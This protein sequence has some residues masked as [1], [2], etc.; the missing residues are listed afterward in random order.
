MLKTIAHAEFGG[1]NTMKRKI[2]VD[3][4]AFQADPLP[5]EYEVMALDANN[6]E[7]D[8]IRPETEEGA[9][10][11]FADLFN[12]YAGPFQRA[13]FAANLTPYHRYTL[14]YL[15]EFGFPVADRIVLHSVE[16]STYAQHDDVMKFTFTPY[17]GRREWC[18]SFH[19]SSL[20]IFDGWQELD[21]SAIYNVVSDD[22]N[23]RCSMTKYSCFSASYIEDLEKL[24]H[25]PVLI[26]KDYK[27][28]V[29]G[30]YY[31]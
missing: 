23:V 22:G 2:I 20:L 31:A 6:D 26:W 12:K 11:A 15:N 9:R 19:N 14:V 1:G 4:A 30:K 18:K 28:G 29:N 5:L 24:F 16:P 8:T 17:R 27:Q 3:A 13:V 21:R 25:D 10:Q 7:L